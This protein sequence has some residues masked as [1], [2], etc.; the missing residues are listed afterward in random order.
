MP[1]H[2]P[3]VQAESSVL[4]RFCVAPARVPER[5]SSQSISIE[6]EINVFPNHRVPEDRL[7]R[8][9]RWAIKHEIIRHVWASHVFLTTAGPTCQ[10]S[11]QSQNSYRSWSQDSQQ[12]A[13]CSIASHNHSQ[14]ALD[15]DHFDDR[16]ESF[17][18]HRVWLLAFIRGLTMR[19]GLKK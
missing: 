4:P 7:S 13:E 17:H 10:R 18:S 5:S 2:Q 1:Q 14:R 3:N 15:P 11:Q 19:A 16:Y 8:F 6:W 12:G 9:L